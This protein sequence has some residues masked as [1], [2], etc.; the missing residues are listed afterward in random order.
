MDVTGLH[1][2]NLLHILLDSGSTHNFLDLE[3]LKS[4]ARKLDVIYPLTVTSGGGHQL[5]V[6]FIY[7]SFKWKLQQAK[8]IVDVIVLPLMCCDLIIGIKRLKS[9]NLILWDFDK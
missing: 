1:D 3:V 7:R 5:E 9:L 4:L 6:A 8:F 2:K